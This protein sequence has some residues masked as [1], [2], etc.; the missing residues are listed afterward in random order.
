MGFQDTVIE[1]EFVEQ[2]EAELRRW[3]RD[4]SRLQEAT[5]YQDLIPFSDYPNNDW[6]DQG[7]AYQAFTAINDREFGRN[8][9]IWRNEQDLKRHRAVMRRF[10]GVSEV[11]EAITTALKVYIFGKGIEI[12]TEPQPK[13]APVPWLVERIRGVVDRFVEHNDFA[14]NMDVELFK[15]SVD[16]G[17]S[18][19]ALQKD[20]IHPRQVYAFFA[21]PDQL[22]RPLAYDDRQL[23]DYMAD[24][25]AIDLMAFVPNWEYGVLTDQKHTDRI[26]GYHVQYDGAGLDWDFFPE[27]QFLHIKKNCTR[28]MKRGMSDWFAIK[29]RLI[30]VGKLRKNTAVGEAVRQAIAWIEDSPQ[31]TTVDQ[32]NAVTPD[33]LQY[34]KPTGI[35]VGGG[36]RYQRTTNY[37]PGSVIRPTPGRKYSPGPASAAGAADAMSIVDKILMESSGSRFQM[38]YYMVSANAS[39]NNFASALVAESPFVKAREWDQIFYGTHFERLLWKVVRFAWRQGWL[40]LNGVPF[41]KLRELVNI[42]VKFP[43]VATRDRTALV[44]QLVQE[45]DILGVTSRKTA[46]TLLGR[47]YDEEI[48]LGAKPQMAVGPNGRP[49]DDGATADPNQPSQ[50]SSLEPQPELA[51]HSARQF[52]RTS[53]AIQKILG[54]M[55]AGTITRPHAK[56]MLMAVGMQDK[57]TDALLD[58]AEGSNDTQSLA[59]VESVLIEGAHDV[60]QE[61]RDHGKFSSGAGSMSHAAKEADRSKA[62]F[63]E[64]GI[65]R[66][67]GVFRDKDGS[68]H[69]QVDPDE[70][71]D[72]SKEAH[73]ANKILEPHGEKPASLHFNKQAREWQSTMSTEEAEQH[74]DD[75]TRANKVLEYHGLPKATLLKDAEGWKSSVDPDD[76]EYHHSEINRSNK[77]LRALGLEPKI[78]LKMNG[79]I[80]EPSHDLDEVNDAIETLKKFRKGKITESVDDL[81]ILHEFGLKE[82]VVS[83]APSGSWNDYP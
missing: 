56:Q 8:Y 34:N 2:P 79:N 26:Y 43:E 37:Q 53:R 63:A 78:K 20:L 55:K 68:N 50:T 70:L 49:R 15:R 75:M 38:P 33:D 81:S 32:L 82:E 16:D 51:N 30:Q 5:A 83:S 23:S 62:I 17:E 52:D 11:T 3:P 31:G 46:A 72:A 4:M 41:W 54:Q 61:N 58:D 48:Q 22:T 57:R 60:S 77:K 66:D 6:P 64:H 14:N 29:E 7:Y 59:A 10:G 73:A 42:S 44:N 47:D 19:L 39:E 67:V 36:M 74:D 45:V 40:E 25:Y 13:I 69:P 21:E 12:T 65:H 76:V 24:Q 71:G 18:P 9:P 1:T 27:D 80:P 35:G 28:N